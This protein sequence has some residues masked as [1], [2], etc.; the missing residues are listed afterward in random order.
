MAR[1][2]AAVA[3]SGGSKRVGADKETER[4]VK[5]ARSQGWT[6]EVTRGNHLKWTP[7]APDKPEEELTA[8]E[9]EA[10]AP[11]ISG[12]T[13]VSVALPKLK[14]KLRRKGLNI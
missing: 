3:G 5:A 4:V 7:P 10:L 6:V 12:L 2:G 1:R 14:S 11:V 9:R 13:A 8:E